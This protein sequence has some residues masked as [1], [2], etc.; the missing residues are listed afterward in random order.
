MQEKQDLHKTHNDRERR[1]GINKVGAS[2]FKATSE[3]RNASKNHHD[4]LGKHVLI[5]REKRTKGS[6]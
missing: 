1:L 6:D 5:L 2:D 3:G 4:K